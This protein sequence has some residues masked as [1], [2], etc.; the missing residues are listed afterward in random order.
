MARR[1]HGGADM[2]ALIAAV[3]L[4]PTLASAQPGAS[5]PVSVQPSPAATSPEIL[6]LARGAHVAGARGDCV[7]ARTLAARI[8]RQDPDF[9]AAV[10]ST[11]PAVVACKPKPRVYAV[12]PEEPVV[13]RPTHMATGGTVPVDR[14]RN[15]IGQLFLGSV[16]GAGLGLVGGLVGASASRDESEGILL[17]GSLGLVVGTSAGVILAGDNAATDYSLGLTLAGSTIGTILGWRIVIDSNNLEPAVALGILVGAPTL[18]A[19]LGFNASRRALY[20]AAST[21]VTVP[22][23]PRISDPM[24]SVPIAMGSF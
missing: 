23:A 12:D 16:M 18:G 10:I 1:V 6:G 5:D 14:G 2:R 20:P 4:V 9:Y 22:S 17:Y 11:D 7:G 13:G 21:R 8:R 3:V 24:T 19:M 15:G